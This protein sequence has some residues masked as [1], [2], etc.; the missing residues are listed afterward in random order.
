MLNTIT[1][2][3]QKEVSNASWKVTQILRKSK[4][5]LANKVSWKSNL[6][7]W[8]IKFALK[9]FFFDIDAW[10]CTTILLTTNYQYICKY[11]HFPK[12]CGPWGLK[13]IDINLRSEPEA[14][15][16]VSPQELNL[17]YQRLSA[18]TVPLSEHCAGSLAFAD[19]RGM[20]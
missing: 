15:Q 17:P 3:L 13:Y 5:L 11:P 19:Q 8:K 7:L 2:Y 10:K 1:L 20:E 4:N 12:E 18:D 6:K 16:C 9:T 14:S